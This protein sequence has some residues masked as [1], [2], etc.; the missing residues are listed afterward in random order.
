MSAASNSN[1]PP[2]STSAIWRLRGTLRIAITC[3]P[4]L[5]GACTKEARRGGGNQSPTPTPSAAL[6]DAGTPTA[7]VN[8]ADAAPSAEVLA[9]IDARCA[10]LEVHVARA[11]E[12]TPFARDA[13]SQRGCPVNLTTAALPA[14]GAKDSPWSVFIRY[15]DGCT[16]AQQLRS[17]DACAY[18]VDVQRPV[19]GR[20][21]LEHGAEVL[22][23]VQASAD[24]RRSAA[25]RVDHLDD[26]ARAVLAAE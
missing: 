8:V 25:P 23:P 6:V 7:L 24:W 26:A 17:P 12:L 3:L 15:Q 14:L 11:A 5:G 2:R 4:L 1:S 13:T 18:E 9:E 21:A 19:R 22:A 16:A 10:G 20:P